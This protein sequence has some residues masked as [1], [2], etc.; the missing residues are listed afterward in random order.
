[1]FRLFGSFVLRTSLVVIPVLILVGPP[2]WLLLVLIQDAL[3]WRYEKV[4]ESQ[5]LGDSIIN[6]IIAY[7]TAHNKLPDSLNDL[8]P[9]YMSIIPPPTAGTGEWRYEP[10][11]DGTFT[12]GFEDLGGYPSCI[13]GSTSHEWLVDDWGEKE[14]DY[15]IEVGST[16]CAGTNSDRGFC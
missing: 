15:H 13:N 9:D 4:V 3:S 1:M 16:T 7:K 6:K 11:S 2:S 10:Y 14:T 5:R 12:L 8:I